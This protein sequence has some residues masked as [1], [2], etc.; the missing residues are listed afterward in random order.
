MI[1]LIAQ[2]VVAV[3]EIAW[4][5]LSPL[6]VLAVG[7]ILLITITSVAP[8][9]RGRGFPAA[10]TILTAAVAGWFLRGIWT[11]FDGPQLIV[12]DALAIDRFTLWVWGTICVAVFLVA[13]LF[14]GY[15]RR[16]HF[17]GPEWYVL[18][19]MSASGG[20]LMA[21]AQDL[22]LTFLGL[23]IL[24]IAVYVLA[25]LHLR[26]TDSQ[27]AAFK[28]FILGALASALFLYGIALIYGATGSTSLNAIAAAR[29]ENALGLNPLEDSSMILAGIALLLIGF[30]F[31]VSA[32]P[33]HMWTPD[34]YEGSPT[35]VVAFMASAVKVAGFAGLVR[36]FWG[37]LGYYHADWR[38]VISIL[39]IASLVVGSFLAVAQTN[40]KRMLAYSSI[41]H[42]GFMLVAVEALAGGAEGFTAT[43][44][45]LRRSLGGAEALLFYL[46]AYALMTIG[47]F[48][49]LTVAGRRG[50]GAHSLDDYRGLSK[51]QPLLAGL[52]AVMLFAQA[53]VP[54]TSGF[55][56]KFRV[57]IA[58]AN[59]G[60]YVL[61]AVAMLAAVVAAVLYL[62]VVVTM[63]MADT[64]VAVAHAITESDTEDDAEL[65]ADADVEMVA[66]PDHVRLPRPA[67][68]AIFIAVAATIVLGTLPWIGQ[69]VLRA[70]A[71][72][73]VLLR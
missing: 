66:A 46:L 11:D 23:E 37:G 49:V 33:F 44:D 52:M 48:G 28:Y 7:G 38:P 59:G 25:A 31:K 19:L 13:A 35:P 56:A 42:A 10:F 5:L 73:L 54:F 70:A 21:A 71:E 12:G 39:A 72:D 47:S 1:G 51:S 20:M 29:S 45:G 18:M 53:G 8:P 69:G 24:S 50:D 14:D 6:L 64:G 57:I 2:D 4:S 61:A 60:S 58:A 22:I 40:V 63:Y 34:V 27:E 62:R 36:V 65:E 3:P 55:L 43:G 9:L 30:G 68:A 41:T 67:M 32:A 16:E 26:R 15:L 17:D